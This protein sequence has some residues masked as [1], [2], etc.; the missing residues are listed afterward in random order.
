MA[1]TPSSSK[2]GTQST[3]LKEPVKQRTNTAS[4]N[5][6]KSGRFIDSPD[7]LRHIVRHLDKFVN[8]VQATN[9]SF[10]SW[11]EVKT[12]FEDY[13]AQT[14]KAA[15]GMKLFEHDGGEVGGF[16]F[17][18]KR[19]PDKTTSG[20]H[21]VKALNLD[22]EESYFKPSNFAEMINFQPM[23]EENK[24]NDPDLDLESSSDLEEL[25]PLENLTPQRSNSSALEELD[26]EDELDPKVT[27]QPDANQSTAP[28]Q[29]SRQEEREA[30]QR[31]ARQKEWEARQEQQRETRQ[32]EQQIRQQ[33]Q[34][35]R[36][37]Q[38][39]EGRIINEVDG[40]GAGM[41][42]QGPELN[43]INPIGVGIQI[44]A[45]IATILTNDDRAARL[46]NKVEKKL[47][48]TIK[49]ANGISAETESLL[50]DNQSETETEAKAEVQSLIQQEEEREAEQEESEE[51]A[52]SEP[53]VEA[54][55]TLTEQVNRIE[56]EL[57]PESEKNKAFKPLAP[58]EIDPH[59]T[60][61][62]KLLQL[63]DQLNKINE[64]MD[65]IEEVLEGLKQQIEEQKAVF[66]ASKEQTETATPSSETL[67]LN[68]SAT[69]P[70]IDP[71][72]KP[73][74]SRQNV[75]EKAQINSSAGQQRAVTQTVEAVAPMNSLVADSLMRWAWLTHEFSEENYRDGIELSDT[76]VLYANPVEAR[77]SALLG[78]QMNCQIQ[79]VDNKGQIAFDATQVENNQW[80]IQTDL[81]S[82]SDK[83]GIS[84]LPQDRS[85]YESL[86]LGQELIETI[87]QN[88]SDAFNPRN[89]EAE[90][91]EIGHE[92]S[93]FRLEI[94]PI[95]TG[96]NQGKFF[97]EGY[98]AQTKEPVFDAISSRQPGQVASISQNSIPNDYLRKLLA[99]EAEQE[100][101]SDQGL[102]PQRE[103]AEPSKSIVHDM[104][105]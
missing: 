48:A 82:D 35:S 69:D 45:G 93:D 31:E 67:T 73:N 95:T 14:G 12:E 50:D 6:K 18:L 88:N 42:K 9:Q 59:A 15:V 38:R 33:Q 103:K 34:E 53:L 83:R 85:T 84:E 55:S 56:A 60:L 39:K 30:Q 1:L 96:P 16:Q 99:Q 87:K 44:G 25:E 70:A 77:Q 23:Q 100:A 97:I 80:K 36:Q 17:Y 86:A 49:R 105:M 11:E 57:A 46:Y 40:L 78:V 79:I 26:D 74:E 75:D 54:S 29:P 66:A 71:A 41:A 90:I 91:I 98:D 8:H 24:G 52:L 4:S 3:Q 47:T 89:A 2:R 104:E 94:S 19:E 68:E 37:E 5:V 22:R 101:S 27:S 81:L 63:D 64:R 102:V 92:K 20:K 32:K 65:R 72:A 21:L 28:A 76:K 58:L 43:G 62:Q 13:S 7:Q 10:N 61:E 51:A